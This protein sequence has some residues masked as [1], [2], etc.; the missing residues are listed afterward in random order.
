MLVGFL[1]K[2]LP[3]CCSYWQGIIS[4]PSS[5]PYASN[6]STT[7]CVG[8]LQFSAF[9]PW[10]LTCTL[11]HMNTLQRAW[12]FQG[13]CKNAFR[14]RFLMWLLEK[15]PLT[16]QRYLLWA[17]SSPSLQKKRKRME[18][19]SCNTL[20]QH[21]SLACYRIVNILRGGNLLSFCCAHFLVA[22]RQQQTHAPT[23]LFTGAC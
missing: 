7:E 13:W 22:I 16:L 18:V 2:L 3:D 9:S 14:G 1:T 15:A 20:P 8:S 12:I 21:C 23:L 19:A 5:V 6:I 11:V 17:L 10:G 4:V